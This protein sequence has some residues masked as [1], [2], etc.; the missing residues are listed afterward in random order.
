MPPG[1]QREVSEKLLS[2]SEIF[3]V[4][5][6]AA[7][8]GITQFKLTG[9]EPL[10]RPGI[11]RL[12]AAIR[13]FPDTTAVTITT[14]GVL[15]AGFAKELKEAGV[16]AVNVSLDTLD[17]SYFQWLTGHAALE[18]VTAGIETA[19]SA[20]LFVRLN[21][22]WGRQ[23]DG[24]EL[25][26]FA[27]QRGLILKFIEMMPVGY[28]KNFV[29]EEKTDLISFLQEHYGKA[30]RIDQL[31]FGAGP[32]AY[33][34]FE[35]LRHPIGLIRA[36][37]HPFCETCNRIRLTA[38]GKLKLCLSYRDG[39]DLREALE[40]GAGERELIRMMEQAIYEKPKKHSFLEPEKITEQ[41]A[42]IS[43]GG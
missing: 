12:A 19:Q 23:S 1:E 20:G 7:A 24:R 25:V 42:M 33:Y 43:I 38:E 37:S 11:V 8:L 10:L 13:A 41:G 28:G 35:K 29:S 17:P 26:R 39:V 6:A 32:A 14:N 22:V 31:S 3:C 40:R 18:Q 4:A 15:L 27:Q 5:K 21:A 36:V 34:R 2:D 16:D 30:Q 9:G